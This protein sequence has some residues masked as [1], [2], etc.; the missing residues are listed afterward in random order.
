MD[1]NNEISIRKALA[2]KSVLVTGASGFVGQSL[3][4]KLLR[5]CENV[6]KIFLLFREKRGRDF[7]SRFEEFKKL[8]VFHRVK[9]NKK[10]MDKL[11][12]IAADL[13]K[14]PTLGIAENDLQMLKNEVSVI[15]HLAATIRF[16]EPI[17]YAVKINTIATRELIRMTKS[18]N[19]LDVF[20]HVSTAYSNLLSPTIEEIIYEP[21]MDY[22]KIIEIVERNQVEEI[23]ELNQ[24]ALK[25]F[26]NTYTISKHLARADDQ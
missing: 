12:P 11:I 21:A 23:R 10:V 1:N 6:D 9:S 3:I 17:D 18:F 4:E 24:L 14:I 15:F 13:G 2:S 25:I 19:K 8:F 5:D 16:D 22:K 7:K 20:V 26:P